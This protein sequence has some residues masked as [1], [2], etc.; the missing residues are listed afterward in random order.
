MKS[1]NAKIIFSV[2]GVLSIISVGF[3]YY[4]A[5]ISLYAW[6]NYHIF[7][8]MVM[9]FN[10]DATLA[11]EV[12]NY[13][14]NVYSN[15]VYDLKKAEYHFERALMLDLYV[16]DA[17]HQL[18]RI[19]F[20]EG[21]FNGAIFKINKQIELHNDELMSSYYIRGLILGYMGRYDEAEEN[22][23][24]FLEWDPKN[25]ATHTDLAWVYFSG[26]EYQK[27]AD[28][29]RAGLFYSQTNPWLLN[30][31]GVALINTGEIDEAKKILEFALENANLLTE[32][33][34]HK[35]YPGNNPNIGIQGL[36]EMKEAIQ[37]NITLTVSN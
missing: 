32:T 25:W 18:A 2:L 8:Q 27:S 6:N 30:M 22:F 12:G 15:G 26:S 10:E 4:R 29:A 11:L 7:P 35:A 20:L 23:L 24:L 16:K 37:Y 31:L 13:Y 9:A 19:D 36:S 34:W 33:D 21:N 17:W 28:I 3:Y 5:E 14:F 1:K